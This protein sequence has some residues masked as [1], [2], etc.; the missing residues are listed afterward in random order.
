MTKLKY[1]AG[2]R[3]SFTS[4]LLDGRTKVDEGSVIF[5][6]PDDTDGRVYR[7]ALDSLLWTGVFLAAKEDRLTRLGGV[8][9]K[10]LRWLR[11]RELVDELRLFG[12][13]ES[14]DRFDQLVGSR[15]VGQDKW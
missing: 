12:H 7:V 4:L 1:K 8:D 14:A 13:K 2:D 5:L 11:D 3:V 9:G 15:Y 10:V 6:R